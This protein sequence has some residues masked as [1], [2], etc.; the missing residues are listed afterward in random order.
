MT[1]YAGLLY[2]LYILITERIVEGVGQT[3]NAEST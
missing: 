1:C 2:M 3:A